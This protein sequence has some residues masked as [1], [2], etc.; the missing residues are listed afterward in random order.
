MKISIIYIEIVNWYFCVIK[1]LNDTYCKIMCLEREKILLSKLKDRR[2]IGSFWVAWPLEEWNSVSLQKSSSKTVTPPQFLY[3]MF[4]FIYIKICCI[5]TFASLY[6]YLFLFFVVT[7]FEL[8]GFRKIETWEKLSKKKS[9]KMTLSFICF[10][11][12]ASF[13]CMVLLRS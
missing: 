10:F 2:Q 5:F 4:L 9:L 12:E 13:F 8:C 6:H 3:N 11:E 7:L 1:K